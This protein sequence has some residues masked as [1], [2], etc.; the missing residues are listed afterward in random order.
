M[1]TRGE[2]TERLG[3]D[4]GMCI[5]YILVPGEQRSVEHCVPFLSTNVNTNVNT[6]VR[7]RA[8]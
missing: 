1:E 6:N 2:G 3:E 8:Q 4:W 7:R 5:V